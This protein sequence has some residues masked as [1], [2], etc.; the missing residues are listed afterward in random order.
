[1]IYKT[2]DVKKSL[3]NLEVIVSP[4]FGIY[5]RGCA[6]PIFYI[7]EKSSGSVRRKIQFTLFFLNTGTFGKAKRE[8][9]LEK[10]NI[11]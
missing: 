7:C 6:P 11:I 3:E 10:A 8:K 5:M 9:Y 2:V 1:M 4:E